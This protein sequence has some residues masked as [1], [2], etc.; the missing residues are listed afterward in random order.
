[1]PR[2]TLDFGFQKKEEKWQSAHH[3]TPSRTNIYPF[4]PF[5]NNHWSQYSVLAICIFY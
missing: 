4:H 3:D 5:M 2:F 1:M